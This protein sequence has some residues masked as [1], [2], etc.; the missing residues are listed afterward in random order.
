MTPHTPVLSRCAALEALRVA[1]HV[2]LVA[3]GVS[4]AITFPF[5]CIRV[6]RD[7]SPTPHPTGDVALEPVRAKTQ[8]RR[9]PTALR[10]VERIS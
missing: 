2:L 4:L 8:P 1:V 7:A 3:I 5:A 6:A 9:R 10:P